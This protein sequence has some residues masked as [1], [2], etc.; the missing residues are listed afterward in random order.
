MPRRAAGL[1]AMAASVLGASAWLV[2]ADAASFDC[3][4]AATQQEKAVCAS[5]AL[6]QLDEK[7]ADSYRAELAR[8][9]PA[10]QNALRKNQD[11]WI[12]ATTAACANLLDDPALLPGCLEMPYKLRQRDLARAVTTVGPFTFLGLGTYQFVPCRAEV[13]CDGDFREGGYVHAS[14]PRIDAPATAA[15]ARWNAAVAGK[16]PPLRSQDNTD[17][18]LD[19]RIAGASADMISVRF[20]LSEYAHRAAHGSTFI[21]GL[22]T[23]LPAV[24]PIAADDLFAAGTTWRPFL[25]KRAME[26]IAA[27]LMRTSLD[28]DFQLAPELM[29]DV[30]SRPERWTLTPAGLAIMFGPEDLGFAVDVPQDAVIPWSELTPYLRKPL[31]FQ[32][33]Q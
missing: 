22:N 18:N 8:L 15:T 14:V 31:P 6:S 19:F 28:Q 21:L 10:G 32:L 3:G 9:S 26:R 5:P 7:I 25:T 24:T 20:D 12:E 23:V 11:Q 27:A 17:V 33:P 29:R 16:I 1:L 2:G 4:A 13:Q 30:V